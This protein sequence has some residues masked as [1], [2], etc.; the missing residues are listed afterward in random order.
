MD[1]SSI[2]EGFGKILNTHGYGFQ[3]SVIKLGDMLF[4]SDISKWVFEAAEFP[5][6]VQNEGTR[7]DFILRLG[8]NVPIYLI[9]ECKKANPAFSNW[10]FVKAPYIHRS[11]AGYEP[12]LIECM[13]EDKNGLL[14]SAAHRG[15][16]LDRA[17][18]IGLEVKSG[19]KG[20]SNSSG[21]GRIEES[22]TQIC[23]SLNGFVEF[24]A[25]NKQIISNKKMIYF[26]PV[27]F[28]TANV[29]LSDVNL[30][31][32]EIEN[33]KVNLN[34]TNLNRVPWVSYQYQLS[35]G[36]KHSYSPTERSEEIGELLD[37]EYIRT[38]IV[39]SSSGIEE[40]LRWSSDSYNYL[41]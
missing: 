32:M 34:N 39:V 9:A 27:I 3:Y 15:A 25:K 37:S 23:R 11:R 24:I 26:L 29:W 36:I 10:C 41:T 5:V 6:Q 35:P 19:E 21:R 2:K 38:I 30:S 20:E 28:T 33:G 13:Q 12:L 4:Y 18:H 31:S 8:K 1:D 22:V 7:I 40:F 14:Y 17:C 16:Q